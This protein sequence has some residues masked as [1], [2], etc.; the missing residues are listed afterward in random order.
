MKKINQVGAVT[1]LA[2]LVSFGI[3]TSAFAY[4]TVNSQVDF[5]QTNS[6]VT[7]LQTFFADNNSIYPEGLVTGYFG[8]LTRSAVQRFQTT[9]DIVSSGTAGTTGFGRVGP[10]TQ[11]K[12]NSLIG[13]GGWV[14]ADM[15]G[16][17]I[18][19]LSNTASNNSATFIW[20][21]DENASGKVFYSTSPVTMNEGDINSVGFGSTS[22]FTA[23]NDNVA[24]LSQAVTLSNLQPNTTYYYVVVA[25]DTKGNV[26]VINPNSTFR[27]NN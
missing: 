15:S 20:N 14:V 1:A 6:S 2:V 9:Y 23:V 16:P 5:G 25:T 17:A 12:I 7:S 4:S 18:F 26:S 24:R 19:S 21:T 8:G 3:G 11:S 10:S 27:T 13:Q 22:G